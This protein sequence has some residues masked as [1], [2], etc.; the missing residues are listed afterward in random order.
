ME[1]FNALDLIRIIA[2]IVL[3]LLNGFF[4]AAE[5]A[6][7]SVRKTRIAE[8]LDQGDAAAHWVQRA[9]DDPDRF[10]AATQLGITIAS[11]G[12]GWIGE[13]A[14]GKLIQPL[15]ELFPVEL[16]TGLSHTISAAIAFAIITFLH[17]VVGELAAKSIALQYPERTS[18][19]VAKPTVWAEWVFK[20]AISV[21][22]GAA[23]RLLRWIGM[24]PP[25]GH[26][27]VHSVEE[28]KMLVSASAQE[29]VVEDEAQEMVHAVFDLNKA[30]VR[31][32]MTPRTEVIAI[33]SSADF[34]QV[35]SITS[36]NGFSK[37]PVYE[38]D[39]DHIVGI[40]HI[41]DVVQAQD[42]KGEGSLTAGDIAR[43]AVFIPEVARLGTLLQLL[44]AR[45]RHIAI[46]LDEYGGT[47]GL[48][49]LDD[50]LEEI[51]GEVGDPFDREPDLQPQADGSV[52]LDGLMPIEEVNQTL[53]LDLIDPYYDTI[54][55][56]MLGRL[57][58]IAKVGDTVDVDGIRLRVEAMDGKRVARV[59]FYPQAGRELKIETSPHD[60]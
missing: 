25:T 45:Q 58:R 6:L 33:P 9:L 42:Q 28:L 27:M 26:D 15:V 39:L 37:M 12:L 24:Q 51:V 3:V 16:Q 60:K 53:G 13:P 30:L 52:L 18:L 56:Y 4:V 17:V 48:V 32:I 10:I 2:V 29:G 54:A 11:L 59:W 40:I 47:A 41:K 50:V 34:P 19:F 14:L 55:G 38:G 22:N 1:S 36:E 23:N 44:R 57:C 31:H 20:P 8:L 46:V 5:F 35:Q 7:V 43:D 49:T 21:L